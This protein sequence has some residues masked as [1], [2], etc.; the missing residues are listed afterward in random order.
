MI[1][2]LRTILR[3]RWPLVLV[4]ALAGAILGY[5]LD[6]RHSATHT[7]YGQIELPTAHALR[8]TSNREAGLVG[9]FV[10]E[11]PLVASDRILRRI[12]TDLKLTQ[13]SQFLGFEPDLRTPM[14]EE[15]LRVFAVAR[16]RA[17]MRVT[18]VPNT[19]LARIEYADPEAGLAIH[20]VN[21]AMDD[22]IADRYERRYASAHDK[23]LQMESGMAELRQQVSGMQQKLLRLQ[24]E[25]GTPGFTPRNN[26]YEETLADLES[27]TMRA[28]LVRLSDT[29]EAEAM[30]A[31][32]SEDL[33]A[34]NA[35][36]SA[37][38]RQRLS[39]TRSEEARL[40]GTLGPNHPAMQAIEADKRSLQTQIEAE[41]QRSL[42]MAEARVEL[43]K[44]YEDELTSTVAA[45]KSNMAA[46]QHTVAD[47]ANLERK[48]VLARRLYLAKFDLLRSEEMSAAFS[49][50][51]IFIV[52]HAVEAPFKPPFPDWLAVSSGGL[53]GI[54]I[55]F[56]F[57]SLLDIVPSPLQR[58]AR[59][60]ELCEVPVL[61]TVPGLGSGDLADLTAL[62]SGHQRAEN[63]SAAVQGFV[64]GIFDLR[65]N[66]PSNSRCLLFT[67]ALPS[68][69]RTTISGKVA[70]AMARRGAK[71]LLIDADLRRPALHRQFELSGAIGVTSVL[72]GKVPLMQA[73]QR[74][75][76]TDRLDV[77]VCGPIPP[78][79]ST[80]LA[81][82]EMMELL[83]CAGKL[84]S[85][86]IVDSP[87]MLVTSDALALS[88][89]M[90][91]TVWVI[92]DG[93]AGRRELLHA[94]QL[95][96][97]Y[98]TRP[99]GI[100][101]NGI[102]TAALRLSAAPPVPKYP[103]YSKQVL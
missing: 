27:R 75:A 92:R 34:G 19:T 71:V 87:P 37:D 73:V 18:N 15:A 94:R 51:D 9:G 52:D 81:S 40:Q 14:Q 74:V 54:L 55:A 82:A 67:S 68:E 72:R 90:D 98:G 6:Y 45:H 76:G 57:G 95:M 22:Y 26:P 16:L 96:Q 65:A 42:R 91:A 83:R 48:Y 69:G 24:Q 78:D 101:V 12:V 4:A 41:Y 21:A 20:I 33:A 13:S 39:T 60:E 64:Q 103:K 38:L 47:Y 36:A 79:A 61:A 3:A 86:V 8:R 89:R 11:L 93:K 50:E 2:N 5:R 1:L 88:Q 66:V 84:Y 97:N 28:R 63:R 32:G 77:L 7:V 44:S 31:Y 62:I 99:L 30:R 58:I 102:D 29:A 49:Q 46:L 43:A 17:Q 80:T 70:V 56:G 35:S 10:E 53:M 23:S 25:L 100:L 85:T 59:L